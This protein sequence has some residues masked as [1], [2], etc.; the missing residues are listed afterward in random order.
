MIV[1]YNLYLDIIVGLSPT[2]EQLFD[3]SILLSNFFFVKD[4]MALFYCN[5][6]DTYQLYNKPKWQILSDLKHHDIDFCSRQTITGINIRF[7]AKIQILFP[8]FVFINFF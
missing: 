2:K 6:N 8:K 4:V 1:L 3:F 7:Q 5:K